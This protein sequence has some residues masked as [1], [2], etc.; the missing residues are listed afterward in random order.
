MFSACA[1]DQELTV[2]DFLRITKKSSESRVCN[3]NH[4]SP[5]Q[6]LTFRALN[7]RQQHTLKQENDMNQYERCPNQSENSRWNVQPNV[8]AAL[9]FCSP[10]KRRT[11]LRSLAVRH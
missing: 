5:Q 10:C 9:G 8:A 7:A 6:R 1:K 2:G 4:A 11:W 3:R